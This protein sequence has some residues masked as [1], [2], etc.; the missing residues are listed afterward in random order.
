MASHPWML[1]MTMCLTLAH[2]AN[3]QHLAKKEMVLH[4]LESGA[5]L[6]EHETGWAWGCFMLNGKL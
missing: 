1:D 6:E 2:P 5:H 3:S 4:T